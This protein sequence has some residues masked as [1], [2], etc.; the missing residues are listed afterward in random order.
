MRYFAGDLPGA[1]GLYE[2]VVADKAKAAP[3]T[4]QELAWLYYRAGRAS[5][6]AGAYRESLQRY[7]QQLAAGNDVDAARHGIRT[8]E[9]ALRVLE[10]E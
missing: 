5:D 1:I 6:A 8:S 3:Q 7:Q 10:M 9:A 4:Y 2:G